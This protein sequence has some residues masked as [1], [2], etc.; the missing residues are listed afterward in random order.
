MR[1]RAQRKRAQR[2][3][4]HQTSSSRLCG[5]FQLAQAHRTPLDERTYFCKQARTVGRH[6]P[7][8]MRVDQYATH[9]PLS[10]CCTSKQQ[11]ARLHMQLE[12]LRRSMCFHASKYRCTMR[13]AIE[14]KVLVR[15]ILN[16]PWHR[17]Q[18]LAL[19][20]TSHSSNYDELAFQHLLVNISTRVRRSGLAACL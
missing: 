6:M 20:G 18:Q 13:Q 10:W 9:N 8:D 7:Q 3:Q 2:Q 19:L 5:H 12:L 16:L 15:S 17:I 4:V 11:Q 14:H 1:K